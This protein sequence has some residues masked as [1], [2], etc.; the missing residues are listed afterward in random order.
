MN[1]RDRKARL[2]DIASVS[3][4]LRTSS[5]HAPD[6]T[7]Q[8][9]SRV[10]DERPFLDVAS[11][12]W[13]IASRFFAAG[14]VVMGGLF[15]VAINRWAPDALE[16][17]PA[18]RPVSAVVTG[19][20]A[21]TAQLGAFPQALETFLEAPA[22]A[23][24]VA[25]SPQSPTNLNQNTQRTASTTLASKTILTGLSP[26]GNLSAACFVGPMC[27][28]HEPSPAGRSTTVFASA[29]STRQ[30]H[31]LPPVSALPPITLARAPKPEMPIRTSALSP[32]A[33][34]WFT[35]VHLRNTA[36]VAMATTPSRTAAD[37]FGHSAT[38]PLEPPTFSS[39]LL[40]PR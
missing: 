23:L 10:H 7:G 38:A 4:A 19:L 28:R 18:N 5:A 33:G 2:H 1:H 37:T 15:A 8:I 14:V 22:V 40:A 39:D 21:S 9:L 13:V 27:Q 17:S 29:S 16:F 31:P 35:P 32:T 24:S 36:Q 20:S 30:T 25:P 11:R 34:D 12:R 6:F 26:S 3:E